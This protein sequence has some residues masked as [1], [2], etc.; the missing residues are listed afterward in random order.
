M[1]RAFLADIIAHPDDDGPRLI[2]ADWCEDNG[3]PDRAEFIRLQIEQARLPSHLRQHHPSRRRAEE[4]LARHRSE[5]VGEVEELAEAGRFVRGFLESVTVSAK[6]FA[7]NAARLFE[8]A[9]V[10]TVRLLRFKEVLARLV[11]CPHL[12]RLTGLDLHSSFLDDTTLETLLRSP[13]LRRL[14]DLEL[15]NNDLTTRG[16]SSLAVSARLDHLTRLEFGLNLAHGEAGRVLAQAHLPALRELSLRSNALRDGGIEEL[17]GSALLQQLAALDLSWCFLGPATLASLARVPP[18]PGLRR[19]DLSSNELGEDGLIRWIQ[20][21]MMAGLTEL[22]LGHTGAGDA[23]A[24]A[25]ARSP[26]VR[27]LEVLGLGVDRIGLPG[28]EAILTSPYLESLQYLDLSGNPIDEPTLRAVARLPLPPRLVI[29]D[30]HDTPL[31]E[32]VVPGR[33]GWLAG[34]A[35]DRVVV[36]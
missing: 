20:A 27:R 12:E 22:E 2:Y 11:R 30:L 32:S 19:L 14:Q 8:L 10:R 26:A 16:L 6:V 25:L 28:L 13:H 35:L 9:P 4:L 3:Q 17:I 24:R 23:G 1:H 31:A 21:G 7:S 5:W 34:T 15:S 36:F 18:P 29:L 33:P